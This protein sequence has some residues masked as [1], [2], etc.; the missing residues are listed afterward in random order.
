MSDMTA[1][2]P[3]G[4]QKD[5]ALTAA[6][7]EALDVIMDWAPFHPKT[8]ALRFAIAYA[9]A[10]DIAP[11]RPAGFSTQGPG[12]WGRIS[13]DQDGRLREIVSVMWPDEPDYYRA[14][15][16][17]MSLGIIAIRD[18]LNANPALRVSDLINEAA[19]D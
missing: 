15:E 5:L 18:R 17:L 10:H 19:S 2:E 13:I 16:T 4:E 1:S 8:E 3:K 12:N 11:V 9:I 7:S 14:I 6:A